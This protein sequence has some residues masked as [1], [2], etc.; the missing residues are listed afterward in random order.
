MTWEK[1][2]EQ[3]KSV[4]VP[5]DDERHDPGVRPRGMTSASARHHLP[6]QGRTATPRP[7]PLDGRKAGAACV[8]RVSSSSSSSSLSSWSSSPEPSTSVDCSTRSLLSRMPPRRGRSSA[9]GVHS[10]RM[11][12]T[13]DATTQ[14]TSFGASRTKRRTWPPVASAT[15]SR[16]S[17]AS[18]RAARHASPLK[19]CVDGDTYVVAVAYDFHLITPILGQLFG[20]G[21]T[22]GSEARATV[23]NDAFDPTPGLGVEKLVRYPD[24]D[25]PSLS[26]P[27]VDPLLRTQPEG[28]SV[29]RQSCPPGLPV[30]RSGHLS[31]HHSQHRGNLPDRRDPRRYG[32]RR[33][34]G[35]R[36]RSMPGQADVPPRGRDVSVHVHADADRDEA[37]GLPVEYRHG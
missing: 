36:E 14:A 1:S 21:L 24:A 7:A 19:T 9:P 29:E 35:P 30:G 17:P 31:G 32:V 10:A 2:P 20:S 13:R 34:V 23:L 28:R 37:I 18:R 33:R 6:L 15:S 22:L 11:S 27:Q 16:R 8:V 5:T 3:G 25:C 12:R 4:I 26:P